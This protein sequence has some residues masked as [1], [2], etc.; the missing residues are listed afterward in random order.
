M[1]DHTIAENLTRLTTA[2][3]DIA[4]AITTKGGTVATGA[5]FEDFPT[6]IGTIPSGGGNQDLV[7]L[8][9]R[10]ITSIIIPSGTTTI[11]AHAFE[12]CYALTSV[13][14]PNTVTTIGSYAFQECRKLAEIN[15]PTS[16]TTIGNY[17][18]SS[19]SGST[20]Q[21]TSI[22]LPSTVS[23]IGTHVFENAARLTY[24]DLSAT[25][26]TTIPDAMTYNA[27]HLQTVKLPTTITTINNTVFRNCYELTS[28]VVPAN[29]ATIGANVFNGCRSLTSIKFDP[30]APPTVSNANTWTNLPTTCIIQVPTGSLTAYTTASNYPDPNTYTYVEY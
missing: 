16:L 9:E 1:P 5:G 19:N 23:S 10:D 21:L 22:T 20:N 12:T 26:I 7:D 25:I 17:G 28:I 8:I 29:V 6:A 15:F 2:R 4:T 3:T 24:L 11:G 14:L 30:T 18:F 13:T 27:T